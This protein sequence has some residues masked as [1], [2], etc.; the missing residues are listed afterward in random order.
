MPIANFAIEYD[1]V[2][3]QNIFTNGDT[4]RGRII[5]E[6]LKETRIK[7]LTLIAK[8]KGEAHSSNEDSSFSVYDKY[9]TIKRQILAEARQDGETFEST[10]VIS[11]GRHVFPF[12]FKIP[13]REMP[14]SFK[15]A[16]CEIVHKIKA[17][18][19]QPMKLPRKAET[20]FKFVS[21]PTM[22]ITGLM[23]PWHGSNNTSVKF[24]GSGAVAMDVYSDRIGCKQ[25]E[26]LQIRVEILNHSTR[27]VTP[28]LKFYLK[29]NSHGHG[30]QSIIVKKILQMEGK[31]V[32]SSRKGTVMKTIAIPRRLPPSILNCS[33]FRLEYELKV[34]LDIKYTIDE[35][36]T[37]PIV[38][39]PD[40]R[41]QPNPVAFDV[42][43][44]QQATLQPLDSPPAYETLF[45]S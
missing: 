42:T 41:Q 21:K 15:C 35:G 9:Y 29:E 17:E 5:V 8:G 36:V 13:D 44:Q 12:S 27:S 45:P 20:Y 10:K 4:V 34:Y 11:Q 32:A 23:V 16:L 7:S 33:I 25:G 37:I 38:V 31:A 18:L 14:S 39:L 19:K 2:N 28:I 40:M 22:D 30:L 3:Q 1:A 24:F 43:P 6:V 26:T